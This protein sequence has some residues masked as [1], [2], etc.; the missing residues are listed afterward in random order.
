MLV[1]VLKTYRSGQDNSLDAKDNN[2]IGLVNEMAWAMA[3]VQENELGYI[4]EEM[5]KL[6]PKAIL[7][8]S[9]Y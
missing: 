8:G 1:L 7:G 4:N 2:Y 5:L 9:I 6:Y 3:F